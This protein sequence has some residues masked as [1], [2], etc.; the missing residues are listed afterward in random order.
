MKNS[1]LT[2]MKNS[3]FLERID[4]AYAGYTPEEEDH[5]SESSIS[6]Y[7]QFLNPQSI[8]EGIPGLGISKE[9]ANH[10]D[11]SFDPDTNWSSAIAEFG[12]QQKE[13]WVSQNPRLVVLKRSKKLAC[14]Q[15]DQEIELRDFEKNKNWYYDSLQK[16]GKEYVKNFV[17]LVVMPVDTDNNPLCKS[18]VKLRL[19]KQ[20]GRDFNLALSK[21]FGGYKNLVAYLKGQGKQCS[22]EPWLAVFTPRLKRGKA[23]TSDGTKSSQSIRIDT[24]GFTSVSPETYFDLVILPKTDQFFQIQGLRKIAEDMIDRP[25]EQALI[26]NQEFDYQPLDYVEESRRLAAATDYDIDNL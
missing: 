17:S 2:T 14:L 18:P 3:E 8:A 11:V 9:I 10:E 5:S 20:A 19:T 16:L 24:D 13:F 12:D 6:P 23:G 26:D 15:T 22:S 4:K 25:I 1:E 21:F 7:F